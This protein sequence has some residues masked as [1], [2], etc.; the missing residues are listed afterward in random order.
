MFL[1]M[2]R[3][4][5]QIEHAVAG[6]D[7]R[8]TLWGWGLMIVALCLMTLS[9]WAA[10]KSVPVAI[11]ASTRLAGSEDPGALDSSLQAAQIVR[12][13]DGGARQAIV[14]E[15]PVIGAAVALAM[16][17]GFVS[18]I[19]GGLGVRE[20]V[21]VPLLAPLYGNVV[22]LVSAILLRLVWLLAELAMSGIVYFL[23]KRL[24]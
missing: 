20:V 7:W 10:I 4:N 14:A 23:P 16:V 22:A 5:P 8:V 2:K 21:V 15:M 11:V 6:L 24:Q 3:L 9:L 12:N 13:G 19:P 17:A 1:Q 18:F